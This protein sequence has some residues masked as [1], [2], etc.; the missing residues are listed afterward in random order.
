MKEVKE[1]VH[2]FEKET[3]KN[4]P[5]WWDVNGSGGDFIK[6]SSK[7]VSRR[8]SQA[9]SIARSTDFSRSVVKLFFQEYFSVLRKHNFGP[10]QIYKVYETGLSANRN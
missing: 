5:K 8:K 4:C 1:L 7:F 6:R 10:K 2:K 3:S 9:V